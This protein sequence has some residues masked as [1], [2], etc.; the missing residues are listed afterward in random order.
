VLRL[1]DELQVG[2]RRCLGDR[3]RP[4]VGV[5]RRI[6]TVCG[7]RR[8][9]LRIEGVEKILQSIQPHNIGRR[10]M[11]N[12]DDDDIVQFWSPTLVKILK[13]RRRFK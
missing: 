9:W 6:W 1:A 13:D 4:G 7:W 10:Q 2:G 3:R 11:K 8:G 12:E 5:I